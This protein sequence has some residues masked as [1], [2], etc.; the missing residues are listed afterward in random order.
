LVDAAW[1]GSAGT[2]KKRA[3]AIAMRMALNGR[4][5]CV[6][7]ALVVYRQAFRRAAFGHDARRHRIN[8]R[9]A[10]SSIFIS[11]ILLVVLPLLCRRR[12]RVGVAHTTQLRWRFA[13]LYRIHAS[14]LFDM[15]DRVLGR[16]SALVCGMACGVFFSPSFSSCLFL[17]FISLSTAG[18]PRGRISS[19]YGGPTYACLYR[20]ASLPCTVIS[21]LLLV[22]LFLVWRDGDW[23]LYQFRFRRS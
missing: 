5:R 3:S 11:R 19:L 15:L 4:R 10:M 17:S 9:I 14:L 13:L 16:Q 2:E 18:L 7:S 8:L 12:H 22:R 21:T 20:P 6:G 23:F 1:M